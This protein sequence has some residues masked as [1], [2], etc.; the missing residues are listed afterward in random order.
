MNHDI[1]LRRRLAVYGPGLMILALIQLWLS[2]AGHFPSP[3]VLLLFPAL[4]ALWTPGYDGFVLALIAGF[5]RDYSAGRGYGLG[6]LVALALALVANA[7]A[8]PGWKRYALR[9]GILVIGGTLAH[10]LAMAL[11][12]WLVPLGDHS[13]PLGKAIRVAL[14][15]VPFK[16]VINLAAA[17]LIT[18]CLGLTLGGW[19]QDRSG[20]DL[21]ESASEVN[22]G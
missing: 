12:A 16:L 11:V 2:L 21:A 13:P 1:S 6:M 10:E 19:R 14:S 15:Q 18:A 17:L 7:W 8:R 3:D 5:I 22:H 9:G 4:A 20:P